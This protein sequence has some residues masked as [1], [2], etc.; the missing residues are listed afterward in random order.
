[1]TL[2]AFVSASASAR[3]DEAETFVSA[4]GPAAEVVVVGA[5]REAADDFCRSLAA[6]RGASF[7]LHR[8]TLGQL[9]SRAAG[10]S[11]AARGLSVGSAFGAEAV[12]A[13][14]IFELARDGRLEYLSPVAGSPGFP[15]AV[16]ATLGEIRESGARVEALG[17]LPLPGPDLARLA[18]AYNAELDRARAVDRAA[19]LAE[20]TRLV[21]ARTPGTLAGLPLLLVDVR[22]ASAAERDFVAAFASLAPA[23]LLTVAGGDDRTRALL[24]AGTTLDEG[25]PRLPSASAG[26]RFG[27]AEGYLER[28]RG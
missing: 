3:L 25:N 27:A 5:T 19:L 7:G 9:A 4:L 8:F 2:R 16:A 15:R 24:P 17:G 22:I 18:D 26:L 21:A 1:M 14:A 28:S 13:R 12:S 11:L 23:A 6:R 20:A 10:A